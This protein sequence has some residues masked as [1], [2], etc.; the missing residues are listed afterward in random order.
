MLGA[1]FYLIIPTGIQ[2][3]DTDIRVIFVSIKPVI[4]DVIVVS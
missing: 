1:R 4:V 3:E 2:R